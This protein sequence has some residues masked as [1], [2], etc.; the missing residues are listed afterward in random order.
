MRSKEIGN[1]YERRAE[2]YLI[3]KGVEILDRNYHSRYGEIDLIAKERD[4]IIFIEVKYRK[5]E[6][7]GTP[8]EMI[9]SKKMKR[10]YLTALE[11]I[12]KNSLVDENMRFDAITILDRDIN[13]IKNL[14][15]GDE[16][17]LNY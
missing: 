6:F 14:V 3:S 2:E 10:I 1:I 17:C 16:I 11:Y 8:I 7:F 4:T 12:E 9:D 13:W 15:I 5:K